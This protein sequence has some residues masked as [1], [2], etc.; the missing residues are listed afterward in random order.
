MKLFA[1]RRSKILAAVIGL[2]VMY[3]GAVGFAHTPKGRPLLPYLGLGGAVTGG[4]PVDKYATPETMEK[5]RFEAMQLLKGDGKAASVDAL[6]FVLGKTTK[7]DLEAWAKAKHVTCT[8][9]PKDLAIDCQDVPANVFQPAFGTG[10]DS[11]F[12]RFDTQTPPR[13]AAIDA[14]VRDTSDDAHAAVAG[15]EGIAKQLETRLGPPTTVRGEHSSEFLKGAPFRMGLLEYRFDDLAVD[16][17][18]LSMNEG[19][20]LLRVQYRSIPK[21]PSSAG[22]T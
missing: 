4:C 22:P 6:G 13:L 10:F 9:R 15:Y 18:T 5:H 7:D 16:V 14:Q 20:V 3:V 2:P 17:S 19:R 1:T 11:M 8:S 12:L 21:A